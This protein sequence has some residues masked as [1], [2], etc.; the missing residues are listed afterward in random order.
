MNHWNRFAARFA[1]RRDRLGCAADATPSADEWLAAFTRHFLGQP[2]AEHGR[3][4]L[5]SGLRFYTADFVA[6]IAALPPVALRQPPIL[7]NRPR[8]IYI[9]AG[10]I[11]AAVYQQ[12]IAR[13]A[14]REE[15]STAFTEAAP[16]LLGG[17][18]GAIYLTSGGQLRP[19]ATGQ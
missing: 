2:D 6:A 4:G 14:A 13:N 5:I 12:L 17:Y 8:A 11:I 10:P 16:R 9:A 7:G 3:Q 19:A 15:I 1:G 18:D